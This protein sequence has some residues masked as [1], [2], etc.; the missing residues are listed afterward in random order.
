MS[1]E[2]T[3]PSRELR[4]L[5]E[6]TERFLGKAASGWSAVADRYEIPY[7]STRLVVHP[8]DWTEGKTLLRFIAPL[9]LD[10]PPGPELYRRLSEFNNTTIFGKYYHHDGTVFI[11]H[12]LLGESVDGEEFR[13]TLASVAHHADHLVDALQAEFGGRKWKQDG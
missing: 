5:R 2:A 10:V 12:N 7:S 4:I 1:V 13:A 3:T 11:E 8:I 9:L 6:K